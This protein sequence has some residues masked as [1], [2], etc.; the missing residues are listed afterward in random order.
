MRRSLVGLLL[1]AAVTVW[2]LPACAFDEV[3]DRTYPLPA[4]GVFTLANVNGSVRIEGWDREEVQVHGVKSA[5]TNPQD[6]QRVQIEVAV[7]PGSV[8]VRTRY[9][10]DEGVEVTVE[11]RIR[12]PRRVLLQSVQTVNGNLL[13]SGVEGA[14]DLRAVNGDVLVTD[15]YGRL[16]ARTTNGTVQLE[17]HFSRLPE[18]VELA[19]VNGVVVVALPS[20]IDADLEISSVNGDFRSELPVK[21][22]GSMA[23]REFRGTLGRGGSPLRIRTVNGGIRVVLVRPT[24]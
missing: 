23:S 10:E 19:T 8:D 5:K 15:T 3:F 16:R 20:D 9:P 18:P 14:A 13:V 1:L 7:A 21:V 24:V 12:V 11:Y 17:L 4:G 22:Q 2:A 6:L